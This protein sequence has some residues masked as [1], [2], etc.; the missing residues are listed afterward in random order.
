MFHKIQERILR[1]IEN[2]NLRFFQKI[3]QLQELRKSV[4]KTIYKHSTLK[5]IKR[6]QE[7][8]SEGECSDHVYIIKEGVFTVKKNVLI[9]KQSQQIYE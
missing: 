5:T 4:L 9:P 3:Y 6:N 1:R 7:I 8:I 2:E